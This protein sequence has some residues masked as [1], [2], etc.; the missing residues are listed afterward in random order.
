M[1]RLTPLVKNLIIVNVVIF[2]AQ[3]IVATLPIAEY[4][5]LWNVSTPNFRP[6]QLFTYMFVHS[7]RDFFHIFFNM[8]LLAF[9]GS[10]LEELWGTKR[11]LLFYIICGIGAGVFNI[12][13]DLFFGLGS[14][15]VMMGASG[16][17]YGVLTAFG[18]TFPNMEIRLMF[19]FNVKAK[20]LVMFL[21]ISA[22]LMGF[23]NV[24][25]DNTAHFTHLGGIVT[26]I[27]ILQVWR[28]RGVN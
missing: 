14:F 13:S 7:S 21:G 8:L 18:I 23:R 22:I 11:F 28:F 15:G 12:F 10:M 16:A 24:P 20:Y 5:S 4:L 17:V 6:Y 1:F 2:I 19:L 9:F 25:G 27:I 3:K 26:A